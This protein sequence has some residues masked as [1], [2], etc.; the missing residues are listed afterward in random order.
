MIVY[1]LLPNK[2]T[3]T[4]I[5]FQQLGSI[6]KIE[7]YKTISIEIRMVKNILFYILMY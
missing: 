7:Y 6:F 2:T 4:I 1:G 3:T 5:P